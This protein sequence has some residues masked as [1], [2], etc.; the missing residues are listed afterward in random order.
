MMHGGLERGDVM[1]APTL[2]DKQ[3]PSSARAIRESAHERIAKGAEAVVAAA[4][5]GMPI[6][7]E[8][9]PSKPVSCRQSSRMGHGTNG[10]CVMAWGF[11]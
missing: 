7:A 6:T 10:A 4:G 3:D 9:K 5:A 1:H 2:A 8:T 11:V